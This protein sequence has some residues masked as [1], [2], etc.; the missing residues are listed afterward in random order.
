MIRSI[1]RDESIVLSS[2]IIVLE[3]CA[4]ITGIL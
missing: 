3:P 1:L 2:R 4:T